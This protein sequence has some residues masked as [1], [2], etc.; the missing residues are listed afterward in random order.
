MDADARSALVKELARQEGFQACTIAAA[1][2]LE[3]EAPLLEQWL[4][5]GYHGKMKW[6]ENHFDLRLDPRKLVPGARSVISLAYSYFPEREVTNEEGLKISRY[7]YG[8]DYHDVVREK[9]RALLERLREK[10]G[11]V[12]GRVFVDSAPVME[13]QWAQRSGMGWLGKNSLLLNSNLGSYFFLAELIVDLELAPD[14]P[15]QDRCGTCTACI[16]ACPTAAIVAPGVVDASR[17]ISYLTIELKDSIPDEFAGRMEGWIFGC[18]ICQEVCPWNRF[19]KVTTETRF[20]PK[21]EWPEFTKREW[22]E[23]TEE[24]FR[25]NF[26]KSAV[27]RAGFSGLQRNILAAGEP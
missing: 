24:V 6:M 22:K 13:R 17:C 5:N 14:A 23:L 8:E 15:V 27:R 20:K 18:D 25:K 3:E 2:F 9:L 4:K 21:G 16:D 1:D 26:P 10:I 11:D 12:D 19:A 7:A